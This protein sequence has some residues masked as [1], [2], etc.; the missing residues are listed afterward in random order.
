[1]MQ[2]PHFIDDVEQALR[3]SGIE[4]ARRFVQCKQLRFDGDRPRDENA[5]A[6]A[7]GQFRISFISVIGESHAFEGALGAFSHLARWR[8][9]KNVLRSEAE[10]YD[11]KCAIWI[12]RID[13]VALWNITNS[14]ASAVGPVQVAAEQRK[15][16]E[17]CF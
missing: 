2:F 16:S 15:N 4:A 6:L 12:Y 7:A 17:N 3:A 1:M 8:R 14:R 11:F 10:Q 5:L 13:G 9:A